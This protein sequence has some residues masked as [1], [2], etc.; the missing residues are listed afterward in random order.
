MKTEIFTDKDLNK[1]IEIIKNEGIVAFPTDT[2][3]G[4][5]IRYDSAT[6]ITKLKEAKR[7][8]ESK[9]FPMMVSNLAQIEEVA[10]LN[11]RDYA[12]IKKWMPG[13]ITLLFKKKA[14]VS[15]EVTNGFETIAIRMP[16]DKLVLS[17]INGVRVP[18]LVPSANISTQKPA[19]SYEEVLAQLDG[20]ID[21][22][23]I[24]L[25]KNK[26]ASTIVNTLDNQLKIVREGP[27]SLKQILESL[28]EKS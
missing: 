23:V 21:G 24:G 28:K 1:V 18:M 20:A 12:L 11:D 14:S 16:D 10:I 26:I 2:V 8:P 15:N 6:A 25:C 22:V 5:G 19:L 17:I 27:I 13:P 4:L 7:R 9:P 3:Y